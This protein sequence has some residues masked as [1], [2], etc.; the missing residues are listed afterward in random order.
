MRDF[1]PSPQLRAWISEHLDPLEA[2]VLGGHKVRSD[3]DLT[4]PHGPREQ[5]DLTPAAAHR[6]NLKG[7]GIG[8]VRLE[9]V[10]V[11]DGKYEIFAR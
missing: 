3:F 5:I 10:S 1:G 7:R 6:I 4:Q 8:K 9:V 2:S 11:G